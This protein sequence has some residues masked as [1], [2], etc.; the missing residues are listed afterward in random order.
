MSI[1][2]CLQ[3]DGDM[4]ATSEKRDDRIA[5]KSISDFSCSCEQEDV[6]SCSLYAAN[7]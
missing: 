7:L 6:F 3:S 5:F 2:R 4:N 1:G